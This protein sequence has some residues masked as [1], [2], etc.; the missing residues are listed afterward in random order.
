MILS[1]VNRRKPAICGSRTVHTAVCPVFRGGSQF[2]LGLRYG[3]QT[4][5]LTL[6]FALALP[7]G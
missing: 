2:T 5:G 1:S 3:A 6:G 4:T 7:C